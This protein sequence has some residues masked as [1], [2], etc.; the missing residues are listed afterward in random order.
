[1]FLYE[2]QHLAQLKFDSKV[3]PNLAQKGFDKRYEIE[4]S[5]H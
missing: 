4:Q 5:D 2:D 3:V 1:M